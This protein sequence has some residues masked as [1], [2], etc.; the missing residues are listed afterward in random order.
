MIDI[1]DVSKQFDGFQAVSNVTFQIKRGMIFGLVGTNGAGKSTLL[2]MMSGVIKP[3]EGLILI[4][5][6]PVYENIKAKQRIFYIADDPYFAKSAT[7]EDVKKYYSGIYPDFDTKRFDEMLKKFDLELRRKIST[8]S[9]GMK[10]QLTVICGICANTRYLY[11]DE[12]FDG[13]DPV[14]RQ[15]VKSIL[16]QEIEERQLTTIIASH[17]LRELEDVCDHV[18][19]LHKGGVVLSKDIEDVTTTIQKIQCVLQ[20]EEQTEEFLAGLDLVTSEKRG[21]VLLVTARGERTEIMEYVEKWNPVFM[22][23]L[24]LSLEEVF[25][26]E[27][28]V[29]GYD[30]KKIIL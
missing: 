22:E 23:V 28:E 13:L 18:G 16:A 9:K 5:G 21:S 10:K 15:A 2:R 8:F 4:D 30:I 1:K 11:C 14:M 7:P 19:F 17:N 12:A 26:R 20:D 25:I 29:I 3:D 27:A 6:M 24:P